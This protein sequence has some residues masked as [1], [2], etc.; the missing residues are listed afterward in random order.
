MARFERR[1]TKIIPLTIGSRVESADADAKGGGEHSRA[2][3]LFNA[4]R[5]CMFYSKKHSRLCSHAQRV[6]NAFDGRR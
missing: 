5:R 6:R 1:V 4:E 2:V 3:T